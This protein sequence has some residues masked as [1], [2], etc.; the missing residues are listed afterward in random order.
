MIAGFQEDFPVVE[1]GHPIGLLTRTNLIQ[2]LAG[3][4]G[5]ALVQDAMRRDFATT[6][7]SVTVEGTLENTDDVSNGSVLVMSEGRLVGILMAGNV[8]EYL[9]IKDTLKAHDV[10]RSAWAE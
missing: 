10:A 7:P 5:D 3:S 6:E 2:R 8:G 4:R 1:A 9:L